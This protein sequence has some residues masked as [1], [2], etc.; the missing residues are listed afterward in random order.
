M[1]NLLL[2]I[3]DV[4]FGLGKGVFKTCHG[5]KFIGGVI[6]YFIYTF[7]EILFEFGAE[8]HQIFVEYVLYCQVIFVLLSQ[9]FDCLYVPEFG[10]CHQRGFAIAV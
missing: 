8:Q 7:L 10:P 4:I 2:P 6:E 3:R 1:V 9:H 5:E